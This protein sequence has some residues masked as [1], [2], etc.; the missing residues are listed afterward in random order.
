VPV[1]NAAINAKA[2]ASISG[3]STNYSA[4]AEAISATR[5]RINEILCGR[6]SAAIAT[7]CARYQHGG[8]GDAAVL[9]RYDS[10]STVH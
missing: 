7:S 8:H 1:P 5:I 9:T 6:P 10:V 4:G 2:A 3:C